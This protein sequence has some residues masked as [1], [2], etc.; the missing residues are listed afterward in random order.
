M[1]DADDTARGSFQALSSQLWRF[2][3]TINAPGVVVTI[4][5]HREQPI[6]TGRE[7]SAGEL[8]GNDFSHSGYD[9]DRADSGPL[10]LP[11]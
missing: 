3:G 2:A 6:R 5:S 4:S 11:F 8:R 1:P 7:W 9:L 10:V